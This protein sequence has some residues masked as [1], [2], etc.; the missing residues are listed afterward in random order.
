MLRGGH[1]S[2]SILNKG[3]EDIS[4][5]VPLRQQISLLHEGS[6]DYSV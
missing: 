6:L 3:N 1:L 2:L 5:Q 4:N